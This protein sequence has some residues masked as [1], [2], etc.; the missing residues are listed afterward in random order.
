VTGAAEAPTVWAL[1][2]RRLRI[3]E[4]ALRRLARS[5]AAP[6]AA[7]RVARSY[8]GTHALVAW[9]RS[10]VGVD[11]EVI[12]PFDERFADLICT[13][14]ERVALHAAADRERLLADLWS[15][16]EALAKALGDARDYEPSR[17]ASPCLWPDGRTGR[18]RARRLDAPAGH[19]AWLVWQCAWHRV[20]A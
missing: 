8:R 1:D 17:L 4:A 15:G 11:I 7:H 3:D 10:R 5:L 16:K 12:E 19:V 6:S 2:A 14:D 9:H 13:A 18:W 20:G